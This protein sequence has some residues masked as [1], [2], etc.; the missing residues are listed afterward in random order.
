M[1]SC[2]RLAAA[3]AGIT[4]T[5]PQKA[6]ACFK[7]AGLDFD[8][9]QFDHRLMAQ[10]LTYLLQELG[11]K[12]GYEKTFSFYLRGTY[13]PTLTKDLFQAKPSAYS[14]TQADKVRIAKLRSAVELRPHMLEVM[15]AY[16]FL[17]TKG[18]TET[19][20]IQALRATKPFLSPRDVAVGVSKCKG[21]FPEVTQAD[22]D[23]LNQEMAAWD[24]ASAEDEA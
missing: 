2:A 16:R 4:M 10:K 21:I 1:G 12:L 18:K 20:A 11:V 5:D 15:A 14:L 17:R 23:S 22:A 8:I 6:L 24:A 13:S 9:K 7:E 19:D 3:M